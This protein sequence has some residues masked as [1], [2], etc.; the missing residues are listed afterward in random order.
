M[1]KI[2]NFLTDKMLTNITK[3]VEEFVSK[4]K[5]K[6]GFVNIFCPHT[7]AAIWLGEDEILHHADIRFFLDKIIP[8]SKEPE[9]QHK[10]TKYLHDLISLRKDVP[11]DER[12]NGHSHLRSMMF[13]SSRI[14][15]SSQRKTYA[16]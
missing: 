6:E 12:I 8:Y 7:T 10:N 14:C 11:K 9:G 2:L 15:S 16:W 13:S 4:T 3:D 5:K 1:R